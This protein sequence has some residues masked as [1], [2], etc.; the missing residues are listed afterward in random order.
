MNE[1][2]TKEILVQL[3]KQKIIYKFYG[4]RNSSFCNFKKIEELDSKSISFCNKERILD[5]I[6]LSNESNLL[7]TYCHESII[8]E[9]KG[10]YIVTDNPKL[11]FIIIGQYYLDKIKDIENK[12]D[13]TAIIHENAKIGKNC[14]IGPY[15]IIGKDV[16]IDDN[17]VIEE[18]CIIKNKVLIGQNTVVHSSAVIGNPGL[19]SIQNN[20][21]RYYN[22][23]HFN[24]VTIKNDVTIGSN[25]VIDRGTLSDTMIGTGTKIGSNNWIGHG[26]KIGMNCFISQG[27]TI[28]GSS[29]IQDNCIIWGNASIRD[30]VK[31]MNGAIV[32]LGSVVLKDVPSG[33]RW[34]GLSIKD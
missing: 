31:I 7:I 20:Q 23:P 26:V 14:F 5:F 11:A 19:G 27:V 15:S 18:H 9:S 13:K 8:N 17:V 1:I 12:I 29:V 32:G 33:K 16:I 28:G 6:H 25:T 2:S 22:F 34:L 10:N 3:D 24:G 21:N 4:D 30:H